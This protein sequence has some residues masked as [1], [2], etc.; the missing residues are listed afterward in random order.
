MLRYDA[1]AHAFYRTTT[2]QVTVGSVTMPAGTLLLVV[3]ASA[4]HDE[5]QFPQAEQFN[6]QRTPNRHQSFGYGVHFCLG[7]P[8]ARL[9]GRIAFEILTQRLPNLRLKAPQS[10]SRAPTLM[11]RGLS[12]LEVV[13]ND[14]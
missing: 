6:I 4:N 2:Q 3:F 12:Q 11:F 14:G 9:E 5:A 7:A 10:Y 1:P 13:W 8:L